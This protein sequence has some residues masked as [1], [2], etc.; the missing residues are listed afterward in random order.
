VDVDGLREHE[1]IGVAPHVR[2]DR[3]AVLG[4]AFVSEQELEQRVL[5]RRESHLFLPLRD[6]PGVRV[7]RD[8]PRREHGGLLDRVAAEQRSHAGEEHVEVEGLREVIVGAQVKPADHLFLLAAR[9][10]HEDGHVLATLPQHRAERVTVHAGEVDVE[11]HEVD[12]FRHRDFEPA[13]TVVGDRYRVLLQFQ[14]LLHVLG[15]GLVV[16]DDEEVHG[17]RV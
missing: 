16:F 12:G 13:V 7:D 3:R 2:Q 4:H 8:L 11:D 1:G 6:V 17:E 10:E 15:D 14:E 5:L 9:G